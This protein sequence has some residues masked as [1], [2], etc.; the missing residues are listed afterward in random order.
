MTAVG[1]HDETRREH[2]LSTRRPGRSDA[3]HAI[4]LSYERGHPRSVKD[5]DAG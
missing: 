5:L 3:D 2:V 4:A 1:S